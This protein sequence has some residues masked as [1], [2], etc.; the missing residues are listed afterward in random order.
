[1]A[2]TP[3]ARPAPRLATCAAGR[4][5]VAVQPFPCWPPCASRVPAARCLGGESKPPPNGSAWMAAAAGP[6]WLPGHR[7]SSC[8]QCSM[9]QIWL[10][11]RPAASCM[12]ARRGCTAA[13]AAPSAVMQMISIGLFSRRRSCRCN[14]SACTLAEVI[15]ATVLQPIKCTKS[16]DGFSGG[17][18]GVS[19]NRVSSHTHTTS[20]TH[21]HANSTASSCMGGGYWVR[22]APHPW[23]QLPAQ[24]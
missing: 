1:M 12:H 21:M 24:F 3:A 13:A 14:A 18:S 8:G 11:I 16:M 7:S 10:A 23:V 5:V 9:P 15:A 22:M 4:A 6:A 17:A 2:T 20:H 19:L